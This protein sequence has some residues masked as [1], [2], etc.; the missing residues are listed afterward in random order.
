MFRE[1][2]L[3]LIDQNETNS[4]NDVFNHRNTKTRNTDTGKIIMRLE[5]YRPV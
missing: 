4:R 5:N 1:V 3:C 2:R